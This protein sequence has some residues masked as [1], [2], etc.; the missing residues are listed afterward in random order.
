ME[1]ISKKILSFFTSDK[2]EV[3]RFI[4]YFFLATTIYI[5]IRFFLYISALE[6]NDL[7]VTKPGGVEAFLPISA[8]MALKRFLF[9]GN[10][11][12]IH[13]AGLTLLILFLFISIVFKRGFCGY[14][15]PI[16]LISETVGNLGKQ[17]KIHRYISYVL[18]CLKYA[19]LGFFAWIILIQMPVSAINSFLNAPY[20]KIS[21]AKMLVFFTDPSRTTLIVLGVLILLGAL[22]RNFWCRFLC[23]YGA[24]LGLVSL[25]SPFKVKRNPDKCINCMKCTNVCP[26]DIQVHKAKTVY[27]AECIGCH[28]CVR[29]RANDECLETKTLNYKYIQAAIFVTF[30]AVVILAMLT[31][32]WQS[33]IANQEYLFWLERLGQISH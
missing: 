21:D 6:A 13:P 27:S 9:T 31:G 17:I 32:Y 20:N 11:D 5:G 1:K 33:N 19:L 30:W 15:C 8:L 7:S 26:M 24:L 14:I 16:G 29:V 28:D 25:L 12:F 10:Y 4:Q 3:R 18:F 22:F 23:P 2:L